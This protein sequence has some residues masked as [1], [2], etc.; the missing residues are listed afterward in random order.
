M[1]GERICS[2]N[3]RAPTPQPARPSR[4][5]GHLLAILASPPLDTSGERTLKR[6]AV[7]AEIVGCSTFEV[8]NLLAHR[9]SSVLDI[10]WVGASPEGWLK[11]RTEIRSRFKV[12]DSVLYGW[13]CTEPARLARQHHRAQVAWIVSLT[14]EHGL[15]PWTVGGLPRHPSR[16]Q[17]YTS[18]TFPK[19]DFREALSRS[20][21]Q[22]SQRLRAS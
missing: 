16:W 5:G 18:R 1:T 19:A 7:A 14:D 9:T 21:E 22:A 12:A 6:I 2:E 11:A 8:Q 3:P 4:H 15:D 13:G 17:R 20:L 10:P